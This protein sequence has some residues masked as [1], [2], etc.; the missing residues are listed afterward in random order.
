MR[1]RDLARD[2]IAF[3]SIPFLLLTIVRVS[4]LGKPYY[5]L[6][7]IIGSLVF[8]ALSLL[9]GAEMRAGLGFVMLVFVSA[10][11]H[12]MSF[13]I[14]GTLVYAGLVVSLLYLGY[15]SG[16]TVKGVALGAASAAAA[17]FI[18]RSFFRLS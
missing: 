12:E 11:Y 15:G 8:W 6:E 14:F 9:S 4:F 13:Y 5:P 1:L 7:L 2:L 17:F 10:Y 18:V 16:R 3:G